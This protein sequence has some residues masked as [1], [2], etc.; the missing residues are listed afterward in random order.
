M[1]FLDKIKKI[2]QSEKKESKVEES[3]EED[4]ENLDIDTWL[5]KKNNEIKNLFQQKKETLSTGLNELISNLEKNIEVLNNVDLD[6]K[7]LDDRTKQITGIGRREYI[8]ALNKFLGNLKKSNKD[9]YEIGFI[10]KELENFSKYSAKSFFKATLIIGKEIEKIKDDIIRIRRL[11]DDFEKDNDGLITRQNDI[12]N[13]IGKNVQK[14]NNEEEKL[15]IIEDVKKIEKINEKEREKL[16][17]IEGQINKIKGSPQYK[18]REEFI[19]EK[20]KKENFLKEN[21]L[22]IKALLDR[23]LLEKYV[24]L[25]P[26]DVYAKI[27]QKYIENPVNALLSDDEI[28]IFNVLQDIKEKIT[29][30]EIDIKESDK[31][32]GKLKI[33]REIFLAQ[34]TGLLILNEEI[35][36][37]DES[38]NKY[39]INFDDLSNEKTKIE[40]KISDSRNQIGVLNKKREKIDK[41]ISDLDLVLEE[42]RMGL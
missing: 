10:K 6:K 26:Q 40:S 38:I 12:R 35:K 1:G 15:R 30:T 4:I 24:H 5:N 18:E 20:N 3:L 36:K 19:G 37:L 32:L 14:K 29:R 25:N 27:A 21:E 28:R 22:K 7:K 39:E 42:G 23:R 41:A 33:E 11:E 31:A 16:N 17:D 13:L 9:N 2:F 8:I 34:R